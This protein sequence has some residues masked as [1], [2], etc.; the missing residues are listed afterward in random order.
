MPCPCVNLC[1]PFRGLQ[2][3]QLRSQA[4]QEMYFGLFYSI[5]EDLTLLRKVGKCHYSFKDVTPQKIRIFIDTSI[6]TSN[7]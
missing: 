3:F 7:F 2:Y 1:Q 6:T 4:A 5:L